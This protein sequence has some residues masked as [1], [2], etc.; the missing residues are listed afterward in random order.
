M[1]H[2]HAQRFAMPSG[3]VGHGSRLLR[4][5]TSSVDPI[6][7]FY[8]LKRYNDSK[9]CS[10]PQALLQTWFLVRALARTTSMIDIPLLDQRDEPLL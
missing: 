5:P 7:A 8:I 2:E 6:K 9:H 1:V 10:L 4:D 3:A